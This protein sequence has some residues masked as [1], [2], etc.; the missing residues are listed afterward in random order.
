VAAHRGAVAIE[1]STDGGALPHVHLAIT[2]VGATPV[3]ALNDGWA[4]TGITTIACDDQATLSE[5]S[6]ATVFVALDVP[7]APGSSGAVS[8]TA[9]ATAP[10]ASSSTD[11]ATT[12]RD[13]VTG[14]F[15]A[16]FAGVI[17]GDVTTVGNTL[18]T[19][20]SGATTG[21]STCEQARARAASVTTG[22][23]N[24][25]W[26]MVAVDA[27]NDPSTANSSAAQLT[28]SGADVVS[29]SLYWSAGQVAGAGGSPATGAIGSALL[30]TPATTGA[31]VP[32]SASYVGVTADQIDQVG[33]TYQAHADVTDLV[34][35][36]GAGRYWL[37]GVA[38]ATGNNTE[39]GWTLTVVYRQSGAAPRTILI[40]DGLVQVAS[41][42]ETLDASGFRVSAGN[43]AQLG[44]VGYEGDW[45]LSTDSVT[46]GTSAPLADATREPDNFF[47]SSITR[48]GAID[49]SGLPSQPNTFGLDIA[50]IDVSPS[51]VPGCLTPGSSATTL[52]FSTAA[53]QYLVGVVTLSASR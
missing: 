38:A 42:S 34:R 15:S 10:G 28:T 16:R 7:G 40:F 50:S 32:T 5:P 53:D 48:A 14:G 27:D 4:C 41:G 49:A 18:S 33:S 39:S 3:A 6:P 52:H 31:G 25:D 44:I 23:D 11:A 17:R 2:A 19:C 47:N 30:A 35:A 9:A 1:V 29:A 20:P 13:D 12:Y 26:S 45:G 22:Q 21:G 51:Q 46:C 8:V 37:G 24:N 36:G 43:S